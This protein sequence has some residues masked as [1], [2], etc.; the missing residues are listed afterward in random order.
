MTSFF[1]F[2]RGNWQL[3]QKRYDAKK[4]IL[5]QTSY[6]EKYKTELRLNLN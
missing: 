2:S 3:Q 5:D 1:T 4:Y 6:T